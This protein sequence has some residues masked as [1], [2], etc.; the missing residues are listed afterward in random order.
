MRPR[1]AIG[2]YEPSANPGGPSRYVDS[3]L[4]G[5]DPGAVAVT[6]FG[7]MTGP[8]AEREWPPFMPV[9][10]SQTVGSG[11]WTVG[12]EENGISLP[13][14][15]RTLPT[16]RLRQ[17]A[18][19][20]RLW[21]GFVRDAARLARRFRTR[22]PDLLHTNNTGCDESPVAARLAGVPRVLG[23]FHV[24]PGYDLNGERSG[25]RHRLME[26]VSNH[27]LDRAIAVSAATKAAWVR[28]TH[29]P[30]GR[31]ATVHN[32]IDPDH[33]RRRRDRA[34]ARTVLGLP[35]GGLLIGGVGRLEEAKGFATLIEAVAL[36]ARD[37]P[38]LTVLLAGHGPLRAELAALAERLGVAGRVRFLGFCRDVQPVYDA[39]DVFVLP[40]LCET[41]GYA[42]LEAMATGLPAVGTTVGGVPEVIDD[43]VT[44]A[45]VPPRDGP[46]LATA[47][48]PLL[49]S[50]ELRERMGAAGRERVVRRFHVRDMVR[51]TLQIYDEMLRRPGRQRA[52]RRAEIT[53]GPS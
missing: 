14:A 42:H 34:G 16:A 2:I 47:L 3:L 32:G 21:A 17:L 36:L 51:R 8:Y 22:L 48:R 44:G 23:T 40:S 35:P 52:A 26:H 19:F 24:D 10:G 49:A 39:L 27:C 18:P 41:L 30:A 9:V 13:P 31:V 4:A 20:P 12:G 45:L 25:F 37:H 28:R 1:P 29:L 38:E 6:V 33:F 7:H 11:R 46:A 50:A 53:A 5:L 15:Q 43:G